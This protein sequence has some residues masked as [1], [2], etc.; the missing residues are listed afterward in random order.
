MN[1]LRGEVAKLAEINVETLRYYEKIKIIPTP[2][3]SENGYRLYSEEVVTILNF[4]KS[5]KNVG[6]S[7][8]QIKLLFSIG[9]KNIDID[10]IEDMIGKKILEINEKIIDQQNIQSE[11]RQIKE[12]LHKPHVCPL[13]NSFI[14]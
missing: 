5:A 13:L 1:Y 14:K 6:F 10:Y 9:D 7:L 2:I 8:N 3:R 11:L 12:N 4:I